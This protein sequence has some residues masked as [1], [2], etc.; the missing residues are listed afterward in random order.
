MIPPTTSLYVLI[1]YEFTSSC[2]NK[3][4]EEDEEFKSL[5]NC[6][7]LTVTFNLGGNIC[8]HPHKDF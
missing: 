7:Y 2:L 5:Y 4:R 3:L 8:T 1:L 6:P